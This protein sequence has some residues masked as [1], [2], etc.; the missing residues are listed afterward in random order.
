MTTVVRAVLGGVCAVA[1]NDDP[2]YPAADGPAPGERRHPRVDRAG[3]GTARRDRRQAPR[4]DGRGRCTIAVGAT[5][6][7]GDSLDTDAAMAGV[8]GW[9]FGLVLS[10]Q[11][12]SCAPGDGTVEWVATDLRAL[13]RHVLDA[14]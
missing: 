6:F 7:V 4:G 12:T 11:S 8:L 10:G 3:H 1:T 2:I 14:S 5:V 9:P 13:V